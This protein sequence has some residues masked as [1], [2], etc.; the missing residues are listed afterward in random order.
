MEYSSKKEGTL[1]SYVF[2]FSNT[3]R[4]RPIIADN[5]YTWELIRKWIVDDKGGTRGYAT[6]KLTKTFGALGNNIG[7]SNNK[8]ERSTDLVL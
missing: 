4:I 6:I 1:R 8:G 5:Q 2:I 7:S 3:T